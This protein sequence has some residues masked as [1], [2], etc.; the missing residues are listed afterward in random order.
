MQDGEQESYAL[1]AMLAP[2]LVKSGPV[3][4]VT[5]EFFSKKDKTKRQA[6]EKEQKHAEN[7]RLG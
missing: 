5:N 6:F 7:K 1:T 2:R 4:G 3:I